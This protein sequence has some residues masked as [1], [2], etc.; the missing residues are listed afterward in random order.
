[1]LVADL[2]RFGRPV[3]EELVSM[4]RGQVLARR[5]VSAPL[6]VGVV[7]ENGQ[8]AARIGKQIEAKR[9]LIAGTKRQYWKPALLLARIQLWRRYLRRLLGQ[10]RHPD[11]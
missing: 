6:A 11:D 9:E 1:M 10:L 7:E 2:R 4:E 3:V 8:R 5:Q